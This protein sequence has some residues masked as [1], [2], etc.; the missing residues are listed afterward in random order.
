MSSNLTPAVLVVKGRICNGLLCVIPMMRSLLRRRPVQLALMIAGFIAGWAASAAA[1]VPRLPTVTLPTV[2]L[3]TVTLPTVTTP[4][5]TT[6]T[7]TTPTVPQPPP[8]PPA[9]PTP[10]VPGVTVPSA[11]PPPPGGGGSGNGGGGSGNRGGGSSSGGGG[12]GSGAPGSAGAPGGAAQGSGGTIQ[13]LRAGSSPT[14]VH[15]LH[16]VRDWIS[17]SGSKKQR[18]TTLVFILRRPALVEFVVVQVSPDCRRIGRFRVRGHR[19]VNRVRLRGRVGHHSLAPGTYRIVARTLPGG[20]TVADTR[21]VVVQHMSRREI[22]A[23]RGANACPPGAVLASASAAG[24][25]GGLAA[26]KAHRSAKAGSERSSQPRRHRGVLGAR[27]TRRAVS[28]AKEVPLWLYVLVGLAVALLAAA[29]F[30]PKA[31]PAG[32]AAS[33]AFGLTGAGVLLV[34]MVAYVLF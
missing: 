29:A 14:R 24:A 8:A 9:P 27:F 22:R 2:T 32:L 23:A 7:V 16:L 31:R 20:R 17:R 30:L 21:L 34:A 18:R 6:P 4:T 13:S 15:R 26:P 1:D 25:T 3:P 33:L 12:G 10:P 28:A 5:V 19:G 11:H